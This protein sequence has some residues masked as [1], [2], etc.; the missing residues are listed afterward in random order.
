MSFIFTDQTTIVKGKKGDTGSTGAKGESGADGAKGATGNTGEKGATGTTIRTCSTDLST[1]NKVLLVNLKPTN[2]EKII[3]VGDIVLTKE[4]KYGPI[5]EFNSSFATV[6]ASGQLDTPLSTFTIPET[7][8]FE[9]EPTDVQLENL[10][11]GAL[12]AYKANDDPEEWRLGV[13]KFTA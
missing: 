6:D 12:F 3:V 4:G 2:G 1:D 11:E 5:T 7:N 13:V 9:T 8:Y 10:G